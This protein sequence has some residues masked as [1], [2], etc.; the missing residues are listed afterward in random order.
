MI[1]RVSRGKHSSNQNFED[2]EI[3]DDDFEYHFECKLDYL[4]YNGLRT[5]GKRDST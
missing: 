1:I 2:F 5:S 4:R 3:E